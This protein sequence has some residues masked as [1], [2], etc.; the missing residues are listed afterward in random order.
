MTELSIG[1]KLLFVPSEHKRTREQPRDLIV[2]KVGRKWAEVGF[3][4]GMPDNRNYGPHSAGRINVETLWMDGGQYASSGR[5]WPSREAWEAEENRQAT[6]RALCGR[7]AHTSAPKGL[8]QDA[9]RQI[10]ATIDAAI[11]AGDRDA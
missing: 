6:W 10:A 2:M 4:V 5:C 3:T 8:S 1:Q 9:M 7:F 11:T